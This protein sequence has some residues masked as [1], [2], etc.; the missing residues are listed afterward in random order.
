VD[1][2][3]THPDDLTAI[4]H[5]LRFYDL[6]ELES[7]HRV[8]RGYINEQWI[9]Q[10]DRERF[11]LKRRHPALSHPD[12]VLAQHALLQWLNQAGFPA[13]STKVTTLGQTYLELQGRLYEIQ[14]Y[15][16][17][18]PY[19]SQSTEHLQ[20]AGRTLGVYH[21]CVQGFDPPPLRRTSDLYSP[22]IASTALADLV[23]AWVSEAGSNLLTIAGVLER[24]TADLENR[25]AGHIDLPHVVIHGDYYAGNLLFDGDRIV[26]VVDFD[27]AQC[28]PRVIEL[29]EALIY[30]ASPRPGNLKH[31]VY[32]GV[33]QWKQF[34]LFSDSYA[35][36]VAISEAE[37]Q[38][39]PDYIQC[40]WLQISLQRLLEKKHHHEIAVESLQEV[41][42]LVSWAQ[43][44]SDR[45]TD[46]IRH[47]V[48]RH[49]QTEGET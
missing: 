20:E 27:K 33:L 21:A 19:D 48:H 45:M 6:G 38:A 29:A 1:R 13:P 11:F 35:R 37:A 18:S 34:E 15:L 16:V 36:T 26:G 24:N 46:V 25:F 4:E 23:E 43:E 17:G 3:L 10:T 22:S 32:P 39:L 2:E 40:I 42:H 47:T 14:E 12:I 8:E 9:V 7:A 41:F 49:H 31:L 30:F 5:V 28:Q 44:N